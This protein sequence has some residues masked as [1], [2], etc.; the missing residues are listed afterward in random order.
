M[1]GDVPAN[2]LCQLYGYV[3]PCTSCLNSKGKGITYQSFLCPLLVAAPDLGAAVTSI[4]SPH[5]SKCHSQRE[6]LSSIFV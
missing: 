3:M 5:I 2:A 6:L 1:V 4:W